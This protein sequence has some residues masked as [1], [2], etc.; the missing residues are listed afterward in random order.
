MCNVILVYFTYVKT[1][2]RVVYIDGF[3]HFNRTINAGKS[4]KNEDQS[5]VYSGS[6]T[7]CVTRS[8]PIKDSCALSYEPKTN[9][10]DNSCGSQNLVANSA[11]LSN[12]YQKEKFMVTLPYY[13]FGVFDGHAGWGAAVA[14]A[15]QLHH[16]IHV[17]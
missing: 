9:S 11:L 14:A 8:V 1:L 7:R 12:K 15:H 10:E 4:K 16:V 2:E 3:K 13:Y 5:A 17:S 6:L